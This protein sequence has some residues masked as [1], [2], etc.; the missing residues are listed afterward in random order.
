M[1]HPHR[2]VPPLSNV[3]H[4]ML[5]HPSLLT[6]LLITQ[7]LVQCINLTRSHPLNNMGNGITSFTPTDCFSFFQNHELNSLLK[8]LSVERVNLTHSHPSNNIGTG[9]NLTCSHPSNQLT[10][11]NFILIILP[12]TQVLQGFT[13]F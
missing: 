12:N 6:V 5:I 1:R 4:P 13:K 7:V 3:C 10:Y 11:L 8:L 2:V 9:I